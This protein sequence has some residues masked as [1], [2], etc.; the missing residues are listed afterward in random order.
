M[1]V[2]VDIPFTQQ[3]QSAFPEVCASYKRRLEEE[4]EEKAQVKEEVKALARKHR[5]EKGN[6]FAHSYM[7]CACTYVQ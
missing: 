5:E 3:M 7:Y 6:V 4:A 1:H 2:Q